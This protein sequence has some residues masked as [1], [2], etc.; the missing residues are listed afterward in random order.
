MVHATMKLQNILC[1]GCNASQKVSDNRLRTKTGFS[2]IKCKGKGNI[3]CN[4]FEEGGCV[5]GDTCLYSHGQQCNMARP[6][7]MWRCRCLRLW[8]KCP[9]HLHKTDMMKRK[10]IKE[11]TRKQKMIASYGIGRPMPKVKRGVKVATT[12]GNA[13]PGNDG[14]TP[15]NEKP[16]V[17]RGAT[18]RVY[19]RCS[20]NASSALAQKVSTFC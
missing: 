7:N 6:S 10:V 13:K 17:N 20:L 2:Q 18:Y 5:Y 1:L 11:P 19:G 3:L 8:I 4:K 9:I 15:K 16:Q 14:D 12:T